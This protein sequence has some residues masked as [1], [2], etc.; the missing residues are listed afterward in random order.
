MNK[1][2]FPF[3]NDPSNM[4]Q[5]NNNIT[6]FV[7]KQLFILGMLIRGSYFH[8]FPKWHEQKYKVQ[9]IEKNNLLKCLN[10]VL[11]IGL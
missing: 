2:I 9:C 1:F 11:R 10:R 7:N 8:F 5:L 3:N 6:T 4:H